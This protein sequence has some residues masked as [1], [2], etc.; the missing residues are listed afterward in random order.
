MVEIQFNRAAE[1]SIMLCSDNCFWLV[2]NVWWVTKSTPHNKPECVKKSGMQLN[3]ATISWII[4][5]VFHEQRS[6]VDLSSLLFADRSC[7]CCSQQTYS[8][9]YNNE[10]L[11]FACNHSESRGL[12]TKQFLRVSLKR[13]VVCTPIWLKNGCKSKTLLLCRQKAP[14][15]KI[16]TGPYRNSQ[17]ITSLQWFH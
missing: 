17:V 9:M 5:I 11:L 7:S 15:R 6:A 3:S 16:V 4:R 10:A 2:D 8:K 14:Y 12:C 13:A 1:D